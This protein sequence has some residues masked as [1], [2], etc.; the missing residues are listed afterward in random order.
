M[1]SAAQLEPLPHRKP[2]SSNIQGQLEILGASENLLRARWRNLY[3]MRWYGECTVAELDLVFAEMR[4]TAERHETV[5]AVSLLDSGCKPPDTEGR[6]R[7][8]HHQT[9]LGQK[10]VAVANLVDGQGFW[11]SVVMNALIGIQ[12]RKSDRPSKERVFRKR[13]EACAWLAQFVKGR[14]GPEAVADVI[15]RSRRAELPA[16]LGS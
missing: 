12:A 16:P 14:P 15:D 9:Q 11:A 6:L 3:V 5:A 8:A 10:L 2:W 7:V 1:S 4:A 13:N